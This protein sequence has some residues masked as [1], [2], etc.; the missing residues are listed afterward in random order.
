MANEVKWIKITTDIFD[1]EKM[2]AI[3]TMPDGQL[4]E[5]IWFKL[6]CLAGKCNNHGFL[7][8]N[9]KIAYTDEMLSK[10]FR[11]DV[12]SVTRALSLFQQLDM[13]EVVDNAYMIANWDKHQNEKGLEEI[14]ENNRIR[15]QRYREKQKQLALESKTCVYCGGVATGVDHIVAKARGGSDNNDNLVPCCIECNRK[16]NDKP[17]VD[18]LNSNLSTIKHELVQKNR[19]LARFIEW[20]CDMSRYVTLQNNVNCSYSNSI[21]NSLSN[22]KDN[23]TNNNTKDTKKNS[24]KNYIYYPNDEKLNQTFLDYMDMRKKIKSPMTDRAVT[25]AMNT[26]EKLSGG[27]NDKAIAILEQSIMNSWKGLFELKDSV[28]SSRTNNQQSQLERIL[29]A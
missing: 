4:M 21:S 29:N 14:R 18:F 6:L 10:V 12:G 1:D 25:L 5:L 26:L 28:Y 16:K 3:E 22:S 20:D 7:M 27:D 15:Q 2:Y 8:I 9:N 24:N 11:V 17:I 23:N 13:I 19:K